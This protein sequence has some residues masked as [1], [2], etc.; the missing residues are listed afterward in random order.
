IEGENENTNNKRAVE[1]RKNIFQFSHLILGV[2]AM[3]FYVGVEVIA[4]DTIGNYGQSQGIP[5]SESKNFTSYTLSA[6]VI[7]YLIGIFT[8]PRFISQA[9]ALAFSAISGIIFT[10]LAIYTTGYVS[11]MFI[12]LL[13]ISNALVWPAIW[14]LA[15]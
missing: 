5:L 9:R 8:I 14:P 11:V 13:G 1:D 3:F 4:G 10:V 2:V 7:G 15:I 6:M 12:A